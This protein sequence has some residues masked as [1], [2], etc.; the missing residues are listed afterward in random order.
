MEVVCLA[1]D[2]K[3]LKVTCSMC[4][5]LNLIPYSAIGNEPLKCEK[6]GRVIVEPAKSQSEEIVKRK[7]T[8]EKDLE[9]RL[10]DFH[11]R[12]LDMVK[13]VYPLAVLGSLCITIAA[14]TSQTYPEVQAYAVTAATLF[15]LAFACSF[16]FKIR[17]STSLIA[18]ICYCSTL[19]AILFLFL[20]V[21]Q[22]IKA[23]PLVG[24]TMNIIPAAF[25]ALIIGSGIFY[26]T[27]TLIKPKYRTKAL[28]LFSAVCIASGVLF[29]VL[30][31]VATASNLLGTEII[32]DYTGLFLLNM[33]VF[34]ASMI[35]I[36]VLINRKPKTPINQK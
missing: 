23:I 21:M 15:L 27:K 1:K 3:I 13:D 22:F 4:R 6:C 2:L 31:V 11:P 30:V 12:F 10:I 20:V 8:K 32:P 34:I 29:I 24:K 28:S 36:I 9:E 35:A 17:F 16:L 26:L 5:T 19:L 7:E 14:F 33:I 18:F 25:T